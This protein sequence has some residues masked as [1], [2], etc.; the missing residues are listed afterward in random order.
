[1]PQSS[2]IRDLSILRLETP[3]VVLEKVARRQPLFFDLL[4]SHT[5]ISMDLVALPLGPVAN[6]FPFF[7]T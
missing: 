1:M 7:C 5:L 2:F 3:M 4:M 6:G